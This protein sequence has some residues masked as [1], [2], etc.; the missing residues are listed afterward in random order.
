MASRS[1]ASTAG[2]GLGLL[3]GINERSPGAYGRLLWQMQHDETW[4]REQALGR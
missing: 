4:R 2:A 3:V 1:F